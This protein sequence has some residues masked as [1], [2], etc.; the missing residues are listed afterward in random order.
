MRK[1]GR[2]YDEI[3]EVTIKEGIQKDPA[4]SV[5]I[6]FGNTIILV[7]ATIE[8]RIPE[9]MKK[10]KR[11]WVTA[12]YSMLPGSTG[13]RKSR[14]QGGREKE[15]QRMIGRALRG[16]IDLKLLGERKIT[17]DCDV[18]QAD[19]GTRTASI[20]GG[21]VALALAVKKLMDNRIIEKNPLINS[22]SSVSCAL[23]NGEVCLDPDY[24]EDF[25]ASVDMNFVFT[26]DNRFIEI[27]GTGEE[28]SFSDEELVKLIKFGKIGAE[29]LKEKQKEIIDWENI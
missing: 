15:I 2:K 24:E 28:D 19:G 7:A 12:E 20:T 25:A 3:R 16:C 6:S 17:I 23:V 29:L 22:V 11:G 4:G 8:N 21:F 26:K 14:K 18:I 27:Q 13:G 1:S 5:Q 10:E 9:W